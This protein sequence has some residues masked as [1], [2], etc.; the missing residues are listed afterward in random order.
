MIVQIHDSL[1]A[2]STV[3]NNDAYICT[4][5]L[6][7]ASYAVQMAAASIT[8]D[9]L[10]VDPTRPWLGLKLGSPCQS[11]GAY[12]QGA[13]DRFGRR[14]LNLPNIGPWAILEKD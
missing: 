9:P 4:N 8:T 12:I 7:D 13:K 2:A 14:Y 11:A 6:V 3:S 1:G 10:F 5:A